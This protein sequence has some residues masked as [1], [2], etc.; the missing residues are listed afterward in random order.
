LGVADDGYFG[1]ISIKAVGQHSESDMIMNLNS[2]RLDFM[3]R[4]SKWD[5][6]GK[7][8]ARRIAQNLKFGAQDT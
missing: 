1:P 3:T 6:F 4:L 7:G 8:W 5:S 2:E